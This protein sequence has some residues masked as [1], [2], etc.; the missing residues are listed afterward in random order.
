MSG[1]R[2]LE[3]DDI[4]AVA[5]LYE[6]VMRSGGSDPP[7]AVEEFF[8]DTLLRSPWTDPEL[9]SLVYED[10]AGLQGFLASHPR[11][12]LHE[13]RPVRLGVSGQL[14]TDLERAKPGT[15]A[16]LMRSHMRGPQDMTLT[17]GATPVVQEMWERLGGVTLALGSLG[18]T[19]VIRPAGFVA[20]LAARRRGREPGRAAAVV[21]ALASPVSRRLVR[22]PS[23]EGSADELTIPLLLELLER[24]R[25]SLRPDYSEDYL[26]WLFEQMEGVPQRGELRR[27][28]IR[29]AGGTPLGWCVYYR[30]PRGIS[31]VQQLAALGDPGP[32]IDH[33][34]V[35][36]AAGGSVAVQGRLEPPLVAPLTERRCLI[37]RSE[38]ALVQAGDP[39][40]LATVTTGK[41]LLTRMEGEWWMGPHLIPPAANGAPASA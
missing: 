15:G 9:P 10:D 20:A 38:C 25:W 11:R 24:G 19:R 28:A 6:R 30:C 22:P 2:P 23:P 41:P 17:D 21:D 1:I 26:A 35:D 3:P 14:V 16:L 13:G 36:A 32:V 27:L 31:Q 34:I 8:R 37:R 33:V 40:L 5:R 4:P 39:R 12:L 7:P 18:W 29:G